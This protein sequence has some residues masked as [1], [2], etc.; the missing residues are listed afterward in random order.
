[1]TKPSTANISP[2]DSGDGDGNTLDLGKFIP[3][4]KKKKARN[5]KK[6]TKEAKIQ[7]LYP[8]DLP[9]QKKDPAADIRPNLQQFVLTMVVLL[10]PIASL[11]IFQQTDAWLKN[12]QGNSQL[13]YEE[14]ENSAQRALIQD[15]DEAAQGFSAIQAYLEEIQSSVWFIR[16]FDQLVDAASELTRATE[17]LTLLAPQLQN[18]PATLLEINQDP[19]TNNQQLDELIT[20]LETIQ[21][22]LTK[23]ETIIRSFPTIALT[24]SQSDRFSRFE[25]RLDQLRDLLQ[26]YQNYLP[27]ARTFLGYDQPHDYLLLFQNNY[28]RRDGGGFI[29]TIAKVQANDGV[30]TELQPYDVYE[31]DGQLTLNEAQP[32]VLTTITSENTIRDSNTTPDFK[33]NAQEAA[34]LLE[35]AG[36]PSVDTVVAVNL[37]FVEE[38]LA[39]TGPISLESGRIITAENFFLVFTYLIEAQKIETNTPKSVLINFIPVF[40]DKLASEKAKWPQFI[41]LAQKAVREKNIVA[42]SKNELGQSVL[43]DLNLSNTLNVPDTSDELLITHTSLGGNK[44]D[45]YLESEYLHNTIFESGG[46]MVNELTIKLTHGY[47]DPIEWGFLPRLRA[48]G[49]NQLAD[50]IRYVLGRGDNITRL[51]IYVPKGAK[52]IKAEGLPETEELVNKAATDLENRRLFSYVS[53]LAP[54]ETGEIKITYK[55]PS[56]LDPSPLD[57]YQLLLRK[58]PGAL[59]TTFIKTYELADTLR[60]NKTQPEKV[61]L[62]DELEYEWKSQLDTDQFYQAVLTNK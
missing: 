57:I 45:R 10:I 13:I 1:M 22:Q 48:F 20:N 38:L 35:A 40:K 44:S 56:K 12:L 7:D 4:A 39:T 59:N 52:L 34:R 50:P 49:V 21:A 30:I 33:V 24:A 43:N 5:S 27:A 8:P 62:D 2:P 60:L 6:A 9:A 26:R 29:G 19:S 47:S 51:K 53:R 11:F 42:Y 3:I 28:E 46:Q 58:A 36:G 17:N 14:F 15:F 41:S 61:L 31:F 32:E 25:Q 55:L 37:S 16:E 23:A 18:L 54:G